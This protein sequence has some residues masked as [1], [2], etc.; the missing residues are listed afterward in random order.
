MTRAIF[1]IVS[2]GLL[3]V[4]T[5][6]AD[7]WIIERIDDPSLRTFVAE[8]RQL[9]AVPDANPLPDGLLAAGSPDGDIVRAWYADPTERYGH[10][11]LGDAIEAGT[12]VAEQA[13]GTLVHYVLPETQ[14]FE[15]RVP[16]IEDLDGDGR[17]EIVT[18]RASVYAGAAVTVYGI[19]GDRVVERA[20]TPFIGIANRWLNIVG[21]A[22]FAGTGD[23]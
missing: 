4:S 5:A 14:V 15:D 17:S 6:R 2:L 16:R 10:A 12:L 1:A 9:P 22:D 20:S 23:K 3:T 18:I 13:D 7:S 19:E 11:I 21:M 8:E